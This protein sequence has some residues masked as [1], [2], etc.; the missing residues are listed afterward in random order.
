MNEEALLRPSTR[1]RS[2]GRVPAD[3]LARANVSS[4]PLPARTKQRL[5]LV[6]DDTRA[7]MIRHLLATVG[8]D[9]TGVN[10]LAAAPCPGTPSGISTH[11]T[12]RVD[13]VPTARVNETITGLVERGDALAVIELRCAFAPEAE[14]RFRCSCARYGVWY[15]E[16]VAVAAAGLI[17]LASAL[18]RS[19]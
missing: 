9:L 17:D 13:W 4:I 16:R 3:F 18:R 12:A 15:T 5:I 2:T 14:A 8:Q 11:G 1:A 10:L 19:A 7:P 6:G